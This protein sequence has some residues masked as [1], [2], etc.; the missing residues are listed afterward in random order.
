MKTSVQKQNA[1]SHEVDYSVDDTAIEQWNSCLAIVR[2]N[3]STQVFKT[4]F[5]PITA[6]RWQ[7]GLLTIQV[8]SQF[9]Y[10]WIE[11]HY[12]ALLQKTI[13]QV[14]GATSRLQY[15]V[16][17]NKNVGD[18]LEQR[19]IKL[20]A[21]RHTPAPNT[22]QTSLPFAKSPAPLH[23]FPNNLNSRYTLEN[24][25]RGESNQLAC[26]AAIA[27]AENP[28][29]TRFNPLFIYGGTGLGKT[30]L[31]QAIGN[32]IVQNNHNTRVLYTNSERF[33][34]DYVNAIQTNKVNEFTNFYR[35]IDVLI[36][37]DIQFFSG[38]EKTQDNFFHTFNALYQAGK[39]LILTSD[40]PPKELTDVDDRL[41]SRFQWGLT[42]DVQLP[43]Y[44]TR[45]AILQRKSIDE[46][47]ELPAEIV[48]YIARHTFTSVRELEGSL[49]SVIAKV[50]LDRRELNLDLAKEVVR[51]VCSQKNRQVTIQD[52]ILEVSDHYEFTPEILASKTRKHE[53]VLARQMAMYLAKKFTQLS[54]KSIG[55]NFGGRD[56]T[57]VLHSCQ[58]IENYIDTDASVKSAVEMLR[59]KFN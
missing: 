24:F 48:E 15:Q 5:E 14:L 45:M 46:G 43:D 52:I 42:V 32:Y 12:Y 57:T 28:G 37:D 13:C 54:L 33:T 41:I 38:K 31:V 49:I 39:Q 36:V 53:V 47:F 35:T 17:M 11:V 10:E 4:W 8:P 19:A 56:H 29:K 2:D 27:V 9:F 1:V 3:V 18:S 55:A 20:P 16:M 7:D 59:R 50:S 34:I 22:P 25:I 6:L 26:S 51:G 44:E 30:H 23:N 58:M 40:K 21:F